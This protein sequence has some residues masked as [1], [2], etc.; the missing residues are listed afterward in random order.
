M[1]RRFDADVSKQ[2][3]LRRGGW[4]NGWMCGTSSRTWRTNSPWR[5]NDVPVKKAMNES[6]KQCVW[7]TVEK[8]VFIISFHIETCSK[9]VGTLMREYANFPNSLDI[10]H[11]WYTFSHN[12]IL[13]LMAVKKVKGKLNLHLFLAPHGL[14]LLLFFSNRFTFWVWMCLEC[15]MF[16]I[17][18]CSHCQRRTSVTDWDRQNVIYLERHRIW[19]I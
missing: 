3:H 5:G 9:N 11:L 18:L 1:R 8:N 6:E 13:N 19:T 2:Q 14:S 7:S 10:F 4:L 16:C 12:H 15:W 17:Y